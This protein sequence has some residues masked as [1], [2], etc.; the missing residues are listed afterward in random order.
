MSLIHKVDDKA[1]IRVH[2]TEKSK[3]DNNLCHSFFKNHSN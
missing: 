3:Y 1:Q 2:S